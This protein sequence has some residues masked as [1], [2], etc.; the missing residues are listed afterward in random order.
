VLKLQQLEAASFGEFGLVLRRGEG[1]TK[2]IRG[3]TVVLTKTPAAF[4]HD[5]SAV[6][7]AL[8][9]YEVAP[10][11]GSVRLL[12]AE[13]HVHSSQ[14]FVPMAVDRYLVVVWDDDPRSGGKPSAFLGGPDDVVVY[15]PGVWHHGIMALGG[16]ALLA[17]TMWRTR[18][19]SDVEFVDLPS[20]L[21]ILDLEIEH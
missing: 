2:S 9:F 17:S 10:E 15:Y 14:M 8:D 1:A 7:L 11:G 21:E 18:G 13:R 3:G 4:Q 19:G 6:D 16:Q 12:Q 20:P 5:E